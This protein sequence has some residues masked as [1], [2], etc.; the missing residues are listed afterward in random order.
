M[1]IA[2]AP[3]QRSVDKI[4]RE[5]ENQ[6][7]NS[8]FESLKYQLVGLNIN[9]TLVEV[10]KT[11]A[12][13]NLIIPHLN[14]D[15]IGEFV[16]DYTVFLHFPTLT[17]EQSQLALDLGDWFFK[18]EP[19]K[20]LHYYAKAHRMHCPDGFKI[21]TRAL[22]RALLQEEWLFN[23]LERAARLGDAK[24]FGQELT[25][26][27]KELKRFCSDQED[28]TLL[29]ERVRRHLYAQTSASHRI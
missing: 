22:F 21:V 13:L 1:A 18:T 10:Q 9:S 15:Q 7:F 25:Y 23:P 26:I 14:K 24:K 11:Y 17:D 5:I 28:Y 16:K 3:T 27:E 12:F 19:Q 8:A 29:H 4:L 6:K 2:A 20:A